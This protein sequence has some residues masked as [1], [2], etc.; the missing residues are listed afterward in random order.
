MLCSGNKKKS[1]A[2]KF[3]V[4]LYKSELPEHL[5][6]IDRFSSKTELT[7]VELEEQKNQS[8]IYFREDGPAPFKFYKG[9]KDLLYPSS[10]R[11]N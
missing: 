4:N 7:K 2:P 3:L 1:R 10:D 9:L 6:K 8:F 11:C 5:T